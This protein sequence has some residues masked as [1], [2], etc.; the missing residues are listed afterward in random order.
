M[1]LI[2]PGRDADAA[3]I[4]ALI[5][6]CWS[7][8]PGIRMDVDV[9]MPE[10][11]ALAG[12][13][14]GK[15]GALWVAEADGRV[16]GMIATR[17]LG[18]GTWEICRV[19]VHPSLH[20]S[21][22][23]HRLLDLAEAHA[24]AA[25]AS[26]LALWSDTRFARAHRFYEKRSYVRAGAIRVLGDISNSLEFGYAKPVNGVE[27]LDVA[28]AGSAEPRLTGILVA[29]VESGASIGFLPPMAPDTARALWRGVAKDVAAGTRVLL[30]GWVDGVL[31]GTVT[32]ALSTAPAQP[33]HAEAQKMLVHPSTR[34]RGLARA[35]MRRL[36]HEAERVGRR[37]LTLHTRA[38]GPAETLSRAMGWRE[39]GSI[40]GYV[41]RADGTPEEVRFFWKRLEQLQESL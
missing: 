36:E 27:V 31:C 41:L 19:Y 10:L 28:A 11:H 30:A 32:L 15:G 35:L 3:G 33:H 40:P 37:L 2:R 23:G 5:W 7:E 9:E 13:Y 18:G 34:R 22:L 26:R 14:A 12:Y 17:P 21:A 24:I 39:L 38:G 6:A 1:P 8:Y 4:I 29:C 25:G 20:G 16:A